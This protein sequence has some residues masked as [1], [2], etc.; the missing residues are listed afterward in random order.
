MEEAAKFT[1]IMLKASWMGMGGLC[2]AFYKRYG[3]EAL[4]IISEVM[5]QAGAEI[6]KSM[7]QMVPA[8]SMKAIGEMYKNMGVEIVNLS[9][10]TLHFKMTQCPMG[11]EGTSKELCE[12]MM[13][14]DK[15]Q[16]SAF[17]GQKVQVKVL[18]SVAAGDKICEVIESTKS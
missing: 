16:D 6:G 14:W 4:P 7:Q 15:G 18:K 3:Q 13:D 9:D 5:S 1:P 10:D 12:A 2:K 8:K 11:I 17:L